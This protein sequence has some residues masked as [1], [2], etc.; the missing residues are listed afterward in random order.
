MIKRVMRSIKNQSLKQ[1]TKTDIWVTR[2]T[3]HSQVFSP[4]SSE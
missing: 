4:S 3:D 2:T 1:I